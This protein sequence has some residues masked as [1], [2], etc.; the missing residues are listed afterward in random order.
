MS[1]SSSSSL[2]RNNFSKLSKI[3]SSSSINTPSSTSSSNNNNNNNTI[4]S[5]SSSSSLQT[6]NFDINN[7]NQQ[8][9]HQTKESD[10]LFWSAPTRLNSIR[11]AAVNAAHLAVSSLQSILSSSITNNST[12]ESLNSISENNHH[13]HHSHN[14]HHHHQSALHSTGIY[15]EHHVF[16]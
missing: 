16:F 14:H 9:Q 1:S 13:H 5:P 4:T 7:Q 12:M 11:T 6:E 15:Y 2:T 8:V 3:F 10:Q